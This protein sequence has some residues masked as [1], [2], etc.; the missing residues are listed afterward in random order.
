MDGLLGLPGNWGAVVLVLGG[1]TLLSFWIVNWVTLARGGEGLEA[2]VRALSGDLLASYRDGLARGLDGFARWLGDHPQQVARSAATKSERDGAGAAAAD[3]PLLAF[4]ATSYWFCLGAGVFYP[5][6]FLAINWGAG[7][8]G[9]FGGM[10]IM[11]AWP[12]QER[13][14]IIAV[15]VGPIAAARVLKFFASSDRIMLGGVFLFAVAAAAAAAVVFAGASA[16]A[17][18]GVFVVVTA[19]A[20]AVAFAGAFAGVVAVVGAVFGAVVVAGAGDVVGAIVFNVA[21]AFAVAFLIFV[22]LPLSGRQ[23]AARAGAPLILPFTL[24]VLLPAFLMAALAGYGIIT[25]LDMDRDPGQASLFAAPWVMFLLLLPAINAPVDWL[26]LGISRWIMGLIA[27]T[28]EGLFRLLDVPVFGWAGHLL[29]IA[30]DFILAALMAVLIVFATVTGVTLFSQVHVWAGGNALYDVPGVI[31]RLRANPFD[32][33]Y[34]WIY[35]MMFWTLVPTLVHSI[36]WAGAWVRSILNGIGMGG[37]LA[38]WAQGVHETGNGVGQAAMGLLLAVLQLLPGLGLI[39]LG[40]EFGPDLL[41]LTPLS[42]EA[43]GAW[44]LDTSEALA[45]V[46]QG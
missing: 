6:M 39:Y 24:A 9:N 35:A 33:E 21:G 8:S 36:V 4:S 15:F 3:Q 1:M 7:S 17:G 38:G 40:Y 46:L 43:M 20:V 29:I 22:V 32:A 30:L 18:A 19:S 45:R 44:L 34:L 42:L 37:V 12:W 27:R 25:P 5:F 10:E 11:P 13:A 14:L 23:D 2:W 28:P 41:A 31:A 26:S 16:G